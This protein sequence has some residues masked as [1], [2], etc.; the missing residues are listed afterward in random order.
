MAAL[1]A[2]KYPKGTLIGS[3]NRN[4]DGNFNGSLDQKFNKNF[5]GKGAIWRREMKSR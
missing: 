3:L 5:D 1:E 4:F 2:F